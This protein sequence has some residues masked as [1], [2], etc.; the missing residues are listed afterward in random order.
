MRSATVRVPSENRYSPPSR[1]PVDRSP[2][3]NPGVAGRPRRNGLKITVSLL[4]TARSRG[5]L[6]GVGRDAADNGSGVGVPLAAQAL[7]PRALGAPAGV[8]ELDE[9]GVVQ[10]AG[11]EARAGQEPGHL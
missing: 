6:P 10:A 4:L 1:A 9:S 11:G 5:V 8:E 3:V 2:G 7:H